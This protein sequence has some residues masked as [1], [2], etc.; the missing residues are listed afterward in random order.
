MRGPFLV[1]W[2]YLALSLAAVAYAWYKGAYDPAHSEFSG[3]PLIILALPWS[4][5]FHN[6]NPRILGDQYNN[7]IVVESIFIALNALILG[8]ILFVVRMMA[9]AQK[10]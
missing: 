7:S 8:A 9:R 6:F 4:W 3:M 10:Q 1:L 2:I 5:V